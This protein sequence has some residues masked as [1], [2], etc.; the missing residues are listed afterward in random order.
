[1]KRMEMIRKKIEV[2]DPDQ[3]S[4]FGDRPE[5]PVCLE[6][7]AIVLIGLPGSKAPEVGR[8][9]AKRLSYGFEQ[10][11]GMDREEVIVQELEFM[12]LE[13]VLD[14]GRIVAVLPAIALRR[15]GVRRLLRRRARVFY[16]MASVFELLGTEGG[17]EAERERLAEEMRELE[18]LCMEAMHFM[19]PE[20][21]SVEETVADALDKASL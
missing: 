3:S 5:R 20:G 10:I 8:E 16:L 2:E 18:P 14:R 21:R 19:L 12:E 11:V 17:S 7:Q 9:L 1:M 6:H 13:D 4:V 15:A